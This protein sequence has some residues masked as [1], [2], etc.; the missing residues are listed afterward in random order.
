MYG[1]LVRRPVLELRDG[2]RPAPA[3]TP[4]IACLGRWWTTVGSLALG[5]RVALARR[6]PEPR[7]RSVA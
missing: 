4:S 6:L 2:E 1:L 3:A 7:A 5:D